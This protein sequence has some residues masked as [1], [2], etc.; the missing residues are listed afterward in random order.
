MPITDFSDVPPITTYP[1]QPPSG[2][3]FQVQVS[4]LIGLSLSDNI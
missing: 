2:L 3:T 1:D 4:V